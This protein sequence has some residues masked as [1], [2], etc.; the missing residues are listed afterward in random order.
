MLSDWSRPDALDGAP[1]AGLKLLHAVV[2]RPQRPP[3]IFYHGEFDPA[4]RAA[5]RDILLR[6]GAFGEAVYPGELLD[7]V[8][9]ALASA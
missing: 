4:R 5:R 6:A 1:S 9:R 8:G 7:L 2:T 3:V